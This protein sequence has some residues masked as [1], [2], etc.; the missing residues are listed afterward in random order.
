MAVI[1]PFDNHILFND[2]FN[3]RFLAQV[4]GSI[5]TDPD[6]DKLLFLKKIQTYTFVNFCYLS[7]FSLF[8]SFSQIH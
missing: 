6:F 5:G 7:T 8:I 4:S 3:N 1:L 2:E